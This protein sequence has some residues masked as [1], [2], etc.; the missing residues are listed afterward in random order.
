[1]NRQIDPEGNDGPCWTDAHKPRVELEQSVP[2][3]CRASASSIGTGT[4]EAAEKRFHVR[5]DARYNL[6]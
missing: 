1:M 2:F 4:G 6:A 3:I 5:C